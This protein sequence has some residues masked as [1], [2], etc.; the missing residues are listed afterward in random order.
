MQRSLRRGRTNRIAIFALLL[1][2][3]ANLAYADAVRAQEETA[4]PKNGMAPLPPTRPPAL[5][6]PAAPP[7][8]VAPQPPPDQQATGDTSTPAWKP[9]ELLQ[10]PPYTRPRMHE[11]ALEWQKMKASGAATEKIWFTFAQSCL[12]R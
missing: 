4:P 7:A 12:V 11:C 6:A 1:G 8:A 9:G 5:A 2:V 10:L 3:A